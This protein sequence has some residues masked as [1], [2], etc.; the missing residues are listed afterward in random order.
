MYAV[1]VG[2]PTMSSAPQSAP[3]PDTPKRRLFPRW[4]KATWAL[5]IWNALMAIW[6]LGAISSA[7]NNDCANETGSEFLSAESAQSA[8]EAGTAVGAGIG[9][10]ALLFLWFVGFI[11][12]SLI[13]LMSRPRQ[14]EVRVIK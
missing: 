6:I 11:I 1:H 3:T 12:L 9:V 10:A 13:W 2:F 7:S 8:C 5:A 4:R 14:I